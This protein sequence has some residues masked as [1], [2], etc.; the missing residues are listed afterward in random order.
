MSG[1]V[2]YRHN[3]ADKFIV[4]TIGEPGSRQFFL[5]FS[6][7]S[8]INT[9]AIEKEQLMALVER[10]EELIRELKRKKLAS[11]K[12]LFSPSVKL[13]SNLDFPIEE[14]FRAG[15]MGITWEP[16]EE[17]VSLEVQEISDQQEF[18]DLIQ[19][20]SD[21]SDFEYPPEILQATLKISQIRG[22]I[23]LADR[24]ISAGRELCPFCGLPVNP[25]GHL[26]PRANGYKR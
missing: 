16:E 1:R 13:E 17:S 18:T 20:D 7:S 21:T 23:S 6:S 25:G 11:D 19:I 14:D 3:P 10:F 15:V 24:V 9:V 22:F 4:G 5:Q 26:C 2:T 12:E 8:G